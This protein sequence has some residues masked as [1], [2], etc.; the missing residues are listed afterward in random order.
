MQKY[1]TIEEISQRLHIAT[2]TARNR[3]CRGDPMP[4]SLK[5]GRRRLFPEAEFEIWLRKFLKH[6][7]TTRLSDPFFCSGPQK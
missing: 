5:V 2:G 3:I 6:E 1:L 4:P 7:I